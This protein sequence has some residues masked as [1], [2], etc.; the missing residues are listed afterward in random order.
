M[1]GPDSSLAALILAVGGP[2]CAAILV[3]AGGTAAPEA[4][5]LQAWARGPQAS[6][7]E[8]WSQER[9][10]QLRQQG[11]PVFVDFTARWCLS[12]Q[13][14]ERV[15]L[16]NAAV[17]RRFADLGVTT[18]RADWTSGSDQIARGLAAFGRASVPLYVYYPSGAQGPVLLPELLTPG[19]VLNALDQSARETQ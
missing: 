12:C 2:V 5:G 13:V 19:I 14:N 17:T 9:V 8:P 3:R 4:T 7:W 15:A 1:L 16:A 18:L 11:T 10:E 6:A